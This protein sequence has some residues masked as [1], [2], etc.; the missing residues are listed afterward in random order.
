MFVFPGS[1]QGAASG[2][3]I[4]NSVR[5]RAS[6]SAGLI[7]TPSVNGNLTTWTWSGWVKRGS[8][9][10]DFLWSAGSTA[11]PA[12]TPYSL[13]AFDSN[14][15][16][17]DEITP[18]PTIVGRLLSSTD[19]VVNDRAAWYHFV[20]V[21]DT[22]NAT[23][24]D[25][26]RVYINGVRFTNFATVVNP[27]LNLQSQM[28][29]TAQHNI[30]RFQTGSQFGDLYLAEIH[31]I[32]GQAL[33]ASNFGQFDINGVW[34]PKAY[35]GTYGT[36]G[37]YLKFDDGSTASNLGLDRSGN[38]NNWT[39]QNVSV[40]AGATYDW[41]TDTP[42]NNYAVLNSLLNQTQYNLQ[43]PKG[44]AGTITNANL[45]VTGQASN[46][47]GWT[48]TFPVSSGK[49]YWE[50]LSVAEPVANYK[51]LGIISLD[52][53]TVHIVASNLSTVNDIHGF[54]L[55][56]AAGTFVWYKNNVLQ[57]TLA[58]GL[59]GFW[60][61]Y[62][63]VANS[64]QMT[65][66]F[67]Q[68]PFAYTP[69]SGFVALN[70]ANLSSAPV[71]DGGLHMAATTYTGT[72]ATNNV[73][74][75]EAFP[76]DFVWIKSRSNA[77]FHQLYDR[78]RGVQQALYS[79][80]TNAETTETTG[81][82][83]FNSNGFTVSTGTGVNQSAATYVAWQWKANGAAVTNTAGSISSQVSA[84]TAAGISVLTYTGTGANATVGHGLGVAPALII[85][86][87]RT[88]VGGTDQG[89][90]VYHQSTGNTQYL[91]INSQ[92]GAITSSTLWNNTSPSSTV[93]TVGTADSVNN[94]VNSMTYVAY[95]FAEVAGFSK[96]GS[97]VGNGSTEGPFVYCGFR[98]R[99]VLMKCSSSDLGAT[100]NWVV[101][102]AA[103]SPNN[104]ALAN[105]YPNSSALEDSVS[106][107]S[108]DLLS[109]GFK[110]RGIYAPIN[111][112]TATFIYIAF[113][114]NPFGG[115]NVRPVNAR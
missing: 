37:Y 26:M 90:A 27:S 18:G 111:S 89:F 62:V 35:G 99:Y 10:S 78:L 112:N 2:Y 85:V 93:F 19:V 76:P 15:V 88:K 44:T 24:G 103:R 38:G 53:A 108:I 59:T 9:T 42:T 32:G 21:W 7:R 12:F 6:A 97:Y 72:G 22:G 61:P 1:G 68:R 55:D 43:S 110:I 29:S 51:Q 98:P 84:N 83:A 17:F 101:K 82:T 48:G 73:V 87:Q 75:A 77:Y 39:V 114:E 33:D 69:P 40:T 31:F 14:R 4:A 46:W 67:G 102:D 106:T 107:A 113:A 71:A 109:N 58:T 91:T 45:T 11:G 41:M 100:A 74:N 20:Y 54:A 30:V 94:V 13:A 66:N 92:N 80:A 28:N 104:S 34:I 50:V 5:F 23:A 25:R 86:K 57:A 95:C 105:L 49:W 65:F 60:L 16:Q 36:N 56:L 8:Q 47:N 70:T 63:V 52:G 3:T 81:L 115:N 96:F 64:A 79:N